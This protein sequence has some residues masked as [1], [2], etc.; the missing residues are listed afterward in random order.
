MEHGIDGTYEVEGLAH[1]VTDELERLVSAEKG[2]IVCCARDQV[3]DAHDLPAIS[4]QTLAEM[5]AQETR[6]A[7]DDRPRCHP[8]DIVRER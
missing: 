4:E 3:V 5:R 6:P 7:R 1:V 2:D 8:L